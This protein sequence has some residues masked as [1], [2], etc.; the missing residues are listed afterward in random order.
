[1]TQVPEMPGPLQLHQGTGSSG[2][3]LLTHR[4][5]K[6]LDDAGD[7]WSLLALRF[8][9]HGT[10]ILLPGLL[11]MHQPWTDHCRMRCS[12]HEADRMHW[13]RSTG[14]PLDGLRLHHLA[15]QHRH[16]LTSLHCHSRHCWGHLVHYSRRVKRGRHGLVEGDMPVRLMRNRGMVHTWGEAAWSVRDHRT[17]CVCHGVALERQRWPHLHVAG[18]HLEMHSAWRR[19]HRAEICL[20]LPMVHRALP[21]L[22][23]R[24]LESRIFIRPS[25]R[26]KRLL[27]KSENR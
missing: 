5:L 26:R 11:Q 12:L 15:R 24:A 7:L 6:L 27:I 3:G 21:L 25:P 17:A 14:D 18:G 13:H 4:L 20:Q 9:H 10:F 22:K 23:P 19:P 16:R 1:M 2:L 8:S